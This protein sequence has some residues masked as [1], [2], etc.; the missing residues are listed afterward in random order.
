MKEREEGK[1]GV[2][3]GTSE[4]RNAART[5]GREERSLSDTRISF[6]VQMWRPR[7]SIRALNAF[8]CSLPLCLSASPSLTP[9]QLSL[10]VVERRRAWV[11]YCHIQ[12]RKERSERRGGGPG[13]FG[14][15]SSA[16]PIEILATC[17]LIS[18]S[19]CGNREPTCE[20]TQ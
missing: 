3:L 13:D 1:E 11:L 9:A 8:C 6:L 7:N 19:V 10:I 17:S 20:N 15:Q 12:R 4:G 18:F 2:K 16:R 5:E 14:I